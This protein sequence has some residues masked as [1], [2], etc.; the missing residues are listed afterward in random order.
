MIMRRVFTVLI[1]FLL[2]GCA[3][4]AGYQKIVDSWMGASKINLIDTWWV[5]T[6]NYKA[7][8]HTEYFSYVETSVSSDNYG[9]IYN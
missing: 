9:N 6:S 5:P 3:T 1:L 8:E 7:D 2:S 4:E